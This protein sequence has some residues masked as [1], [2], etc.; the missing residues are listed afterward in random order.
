MLLRQRDRTAKN[1]Y[2]QLKDKSLPEVSVETRALLVCSSC[3]I[4]G[5]AIAILHLSAGA[6]KCADRK[7]YVKE[8]GSLP[9]H[10]ARTL[11]ARRICLGHIISS[12]LI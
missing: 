10:I 6:L 3:E 9:H 5:I 7:H 8:H 1:S 2:L 11:I 12:I 4:W